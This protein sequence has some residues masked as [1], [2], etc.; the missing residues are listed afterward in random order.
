VIKKIRRL[1]YKSWITGLIGGAISGGCSGL[2]A[3]GIVSFIDPKDFG[4]SWKTLGLMAGV[5]VTGAI[6]GFLQRLS[7]SPMP[8]VV[9]EEIEVPTDDHSRDAEIVKTET[10]L[11]GGVSVTTETPPSPEPPPVEPPAQ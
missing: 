5:F 3:G 9:V 6:T 1:D 7:Q 11:G 4:V 2:T 8:T 10:Q